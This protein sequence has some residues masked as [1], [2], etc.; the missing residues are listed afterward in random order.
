MLCKSEV[1]RVRVGV[2]F[3]KPDSV[4]ISSTSCKFERPPCLVPHSRWKRLLST[5]VHT[6]AR[7]WAH[8]SVSNQL[9]VWFLD[10]LLHLRPSARCSTVPKDLFFEVDGCDPHTAAGATRWLSVGVGGV[11]QSEACFVNGLVGVKR[12]VVVACRGAK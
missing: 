6:D 3:G 7:C 10:A 4:V 2:V 9:Y 1:G 8:C 5:S 11:D 12:G